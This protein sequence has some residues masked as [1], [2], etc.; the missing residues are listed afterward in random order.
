MGGGV[1]VWISRSMP[2]CPCGTQR[3]IFKSK[4]SPAWESQV[5]NS[6]YQ[7][8]RQQPLPPSHLTGPSSH[9]FKWCFG[10]HLTNFRRSIFS[11]KASLHSA[12]HAWQT[13]LLLTTQRSLFLLCSDSYRSQVTGWTGTMVKSERAVRKVVNDLVSSWLR[14][15]KLAL[16]Q[17]SGTCLMLITLH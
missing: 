15:C 8:W 1:G 2:R 10:S 6:Y 16:I 14:R 3:A 7:A 4:L 11:T 12:H 17:S 9:I 5:S 13:I